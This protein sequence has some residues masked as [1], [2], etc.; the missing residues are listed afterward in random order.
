MMNEQ[1]IHGIFI[2]VIT[3]FTSDHKLDTAAFRKYIS[4]I[5]AQDIQGIVINGTTGEAP[6]VRWEEAAEMIAITKDVLNKMNKTIPVVAGTGTNDTYATVDRTVKAAEAGADAAMVVTP[7]YS[8]P[9]QAGILEHFRLASG[10]GLPV[11]IYEIPARTGSRITLDTMIQIMG[12][13]GVSGLKDCSGG[14]ELLG[15]LKAHTSKPVLCGDDAGFLQ[16]LDNG[17]A[18]GMLASANIHTG[19]F[20]DVYRL[21]AQG[22][23]AEAASR[24]EALQP[25]IGRVFEEPAPAPLKWYL[26]KQGIIESPALRLPLMPVSDELADKLDDT[27]NKM[28]AIFTFFNVDTFK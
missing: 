14:C 25:L 19:R 21:Y 28:R 5:A 13:D 4:A 10:T 22:Q 1:N 15:A 24:F 12:L 11:L 3:P 23:T 8:R 20:S 18:G 27:M 26:A 9:T 17:A 7:Y 16:M 6:T 2:P